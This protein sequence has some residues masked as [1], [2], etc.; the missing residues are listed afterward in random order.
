MVA[1][2]PQNAVRQRFGT[3]AR[4]AAVSLALATTIVS[5]AVAHEATNNGITVAHPWVRATPGGATLSSA[6]LEIKGGETG[7]RLVGGSADGAGRVEIHTH[8]HDGDIMRMRRV[9]GIDIPAGG[10]KVFR[11]SGDHI[12]LMDLKGPLAEGDLVKLTLN[13]AKAGAVEIDATVEP[14]GAMGPHGMDHQPGH[15]GEASGAQTGADS[16]AHRHH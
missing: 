7:D 14:I 10:S 3:L 11:P 6:Y 8:V 9:D 2:T 12:M 16:D 15:D 4:G 1:P 5:F 13:F